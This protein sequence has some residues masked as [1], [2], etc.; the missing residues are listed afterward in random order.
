MLLDRTKDLPYTVQIS[1]GMEVM[2]PQNMVISASMDSG[3]RD[4]VIDIALES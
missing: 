3:L 1:V 2:V 4:T